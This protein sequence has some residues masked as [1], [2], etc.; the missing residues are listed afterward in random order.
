MPRRSRR[1]GL[2]GWL[3]RLFPAEFRGDFGTEMAADFQDQRADAAVA[4]R[5]SVARLWAR[6]LLD[7]ARRA[8]LEHLD[9]LRRDAGYALRLLRRR[10]AFATTVV[11]TLAI[12]VGLNTAVFSVVSGVLFRDLPLPNG[13]RVVRLAQ[14]EA[15]APGDLQDTSSAD[16]LDWQTRTKTLDALALSTMSSPGTLI[17]PV[18]DPETIAGLVVTERFFDI[19]GATP[20]LG[21]RFTADEYRNGTMLNRFETSPSV[22]ILSHA[23]WREHFGGQSDVVGT[24]FRVGG[25]MFEVVGVMPAELDLR[26]VVRFPDARYL[27]PG[28]P[29]TAGAMS[30]RRN[31][32]ATAIGRLAPGVSRQRAQTEFDAISRGLAGA[33]PEDAGWSVKVVSPLESIVTTVRTGLWLLSAAALCVL[34]VAAANVTNLLL[35]HASGR[36]LE[37]ATRAAIGATRAHLVRQLLTEGLVLS[38]LGGALGIALAY[39]S[40]PALI[41]LAP[42]TVP[43]L[44]EITVD[45]R[46]FAFAL[47]TSVSVGIACGLAAALSL[48]RRG[49]DTAIR[50]GRLDARSHGRRFRQGLTVAQVALALLLVVAAGLL[51]R[52]VRALGALELG[53]DPHNVISVNA[54][55]D[56]RKVRDIGGMT[57]FNAA[58]IEQ[59]RQLPR[60]VALGTGPEPLRPATGT[61][62]SASPDVDGEMIEVNPVTPGYLRALRSRLILGRLFDEADQTGNA[63]LAI[64]SESAARHFWPDA[65]PI[66]QPLFMNRGA[67]PTVVG[68]VADIRRSGLEGEFSPTVYILQTQ[69]THLG[70]SSILIQT[71]GDPRDIVP[72]IR[73]ALKRLDPEAP[74]GGVRTLEELID[75][76]MAPRRFMLRLVGLFSMLALGL[77]MLGIYGVLAE[78]VAQR[79]PEIGVRMALGADRRTVIGLVLSQGAWMVGVGVALGAAAAYAFRDVMSSFVFGVPTSDG[80]TFTTACAGVILAA[81]IASSLPAR[82]AA[83][84]DPVVALRQE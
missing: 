9:V 43:R 74:L 50:S 4:G 27:L 57:A 65:N 56:R 51:V 7:V 8:P 31:R 14:V 76:E 15:T 53:F 49:L 68:V 71:E 47:V 6:T 13:E 59:V 3:L 20:A 61:A 25:R 66:G 30:S 82:R 2:F 28:R 52:T 63:A 26:G 83:S 19:I 58:L 32:G 23:L 70:I 69:S 84:V 78:S 17:T 42:D 79:V 48:D 36:R 72:A 75:G 24:T 80:L 81:L 40:V 77:A 1:E 37:L 18:G 55:P 67:Q 54:S 12:G 45:G 64:V 44:E 29:N 22:A 39:W 46:V 21:R 38:G 5:R 33:H 62:V 11:L 41:A 73:G 16:F 35:A 10:P 60:V 34:L